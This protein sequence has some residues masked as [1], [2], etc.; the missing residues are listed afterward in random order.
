MSDFDGSAR[1]A[2]VSLQPLLSVHRFTTE[3]SDGGLRVMVRPPK[4][5][6]LDEPA[7]ILAEGLITCVRRQDDGDRWWWFLDG[8]PLAE[9]D[10]P[11]EAITA[12]KGAFAVRLDAR[13]A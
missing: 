6:P 3:L 1:R 10:H 2:L 4:T 12:L 5:D 9:I 13:G 8:A 11:Y 7:D